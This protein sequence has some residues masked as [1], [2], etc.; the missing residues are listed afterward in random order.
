M[1]MTTG[2]GFKCPKCGS[3]VDIYVGEGP[4]RCSNCSTLMVANPQARIAANV[5]CPT[6]K[7][8]MG[9][10]NSDRCSTCGGPLTRMPA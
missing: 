8:S 9:L 5:Y 2:F 7:S 10:T 3:S 1:S 4:P 6:C